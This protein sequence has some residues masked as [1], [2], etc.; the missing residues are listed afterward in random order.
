MIQQ[1]LLT[2]GGSFTVA[3][4]AEDA[5]RCGKHGDDSIH[6]HVAVV[7]DPDRLTA[8]GF[9]LDHNKIQSYF[10]QAYIAAEVL[11]S[12]ERMAMKACE[13]LARL[14]GCPVRLEVTVGGTPQ[15]GLTA[16]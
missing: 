5:T 8:E 10:E 12:C 4:G 2:R 16:F 15:S 13:D 6:Y 7:G 1:L 9:V 3:A 14:I 11:P